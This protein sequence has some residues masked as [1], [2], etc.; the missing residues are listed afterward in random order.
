MKSCRELEALSIVDWLI[1]ISNL[2]NNSESH[3]K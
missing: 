1:V 3:T 2:G